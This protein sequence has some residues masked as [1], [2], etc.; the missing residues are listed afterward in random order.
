[1]SAALS[2]PRVPAVTQSGDAQAPA[3]PEPPDGQRAAVLDPAGAA[4]MRAGFI[5]FYDRE[6][7]A[8]VRFLMWRGASRTTAD[9]AA[10]EAF[11]EAWT[12]MTPEGTCGVASP[13]AW[14]RTLAYRRYR[15]PTG[16]RRARPA[17]LVADVPDRAQP[18]EG[19]AE[20]TDQTLLVLDALRGLRP[21]ALAVM[22][23][24]LDGFTGPEIAA[25]LG[26]TQQQE[27]D[28]LKHAR[29]NLAR[30]LAQG[31]GPPMPDPAALPFPEPDES[32][33]DAVLA[34][35]RRDLLDHL[36][37]T[38]SPDTVLLAIMGADRTLTAA[39]GTASPDLLSPPARPT[40]SPAAGREC[41]PAFIL[42][43]RSIADSFT[44]HLLQAMDGAQFL[45]DGR[46]RISAAGRAACPG[47]PRR[48]TH[49]SATWAPGLDA[50]LPVVL[51][52]VVEALSDTRRGAGAMAHAS[53]AWVTDVPPLDDFCRAL[54]DFCRA[55]EGIICRAV[56]VKI[57]S[58]RD[59]DR[60][61]APARTLGAR[62]DYELPVLYRLVP[63]RWLADVRVD[64]S[65]ADL[66]RA[67]I[68]DPATL[69]GVI[70]TPA[71]RWPPGAAAQVRA[72][73]RE[74]SP[75]IYQITGGSPRDLSDLIT[76]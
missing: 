74:I 55:V 75:G 2:R 69:D 32:G 43:M 26:I 16:P 66:S 64:A 76:I 3:D 45:E 15:R 19:H 34:A 33:L 22:A 4:Q 40:A 6:Y 54:D 63:L 12:R 20:L 11:L 61:V 53:A 39:D 62:L 58:E 31:E 17:S 38:A 28:L 65:G 25:Q 21:D 5:E 7:L 14:I 13:R 42:D 44:R 9:D 46:F 27:R 10:Q 24:H 47:Q 41:L 18:G 8:V 29:K 68:S 23:F 56:E 35:V 71:T 73:S 60:A 36:R 52:A 51:R 49:S 50:P 37:D 72:R 67:D 48:G 57:A 30:Q 70:W 59:E 1:M